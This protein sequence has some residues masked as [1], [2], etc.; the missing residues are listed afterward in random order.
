[1]MAEHENGRTGS[2]GIIVSGGS[3]D[4]TFALAFL[5]AY[6]ADVLIA[7]DRGLVFCQKYGITPDAVVGDFDSA[8][9]SCLSLYELSGDGP[10]VRTFQPE[11]DW[12]DTEL[13]VRMAV[14]FG[15]H[16][17]VLLG[18]TGTRLDHVLGNLQ[19]MDLAFSMG[20]DLQ[21]LDPHN[22][23]TMHGSGFEILREDVWGDYISFIPWG[24]EVTG[25]P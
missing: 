15:V 1:M 17:A 10:L 14:E 13:A 25:L 20:L 22:R 3:L 4:E 11:K 6:R 18:G 5:Q 9:K 2:R 21:L 7:A 23:V 24:G 16:T 8:D 12:T 19:V